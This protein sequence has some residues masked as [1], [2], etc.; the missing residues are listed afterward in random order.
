MTERAREI[1]EKMKGLSLVDMLALHERLV[2]SIQEKEGALEPA[3]RAEIE[4]RIEEIEAG[5]AE[6]V[7][8]FEALRAM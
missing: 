4:R 3:Y 1:E 7:D 5:K 2:A 6:G 8:A